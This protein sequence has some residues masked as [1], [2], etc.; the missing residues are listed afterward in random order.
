MNLSLFWGLELKSNFWKSAIDY[1]INPI[2]QIPNPTYSLIE[3]IPLFLF[4]SFEVKNTKTSPAVT[5]TQSPWINQTMKKRYELS[6]IFL[7]LLS[8]FFL[9]IRYSKNPPNLVVQSITIPAAKICLF[10][11][12][13]ELHRQNNVAIMKVKLPVTS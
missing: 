11:K 8:Y 1:A 12:L 10:D 7:N 13:T 3:I 4:G 5:V 6:L 9:K 2:S